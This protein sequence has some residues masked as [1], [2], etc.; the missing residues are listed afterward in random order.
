MTAHTVAHVGRDGIA[1]H[2]VIAKDGKHVDLAPGEVRE[3]AAFLATVMA[4]AVP[5]VVNR[6][7]QT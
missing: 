7:D 3:L 4:D 6:P 1:F 5:N 2:V